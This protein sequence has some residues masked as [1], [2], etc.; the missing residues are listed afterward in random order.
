MTKWDTLEPLTKNIIKTAS[1]AAGVY[2]LAFVAKSIR[3][4]GHALPKF[5]DDIDIE[6][7]LPIMY[8]YTMAHALHRVYVVLKREENYTEEKFKQ[9]K[10]CITKLSEFMTVTLD[11]EDVKK[12]NKMIEK[13]EDLFKN[14]VNTFKDPLTLSIIEQDMELITGAMSAH[15]H[16]LMIDK[17]T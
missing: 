4:S 9:L 7:L 13:I 17:F 1:A 5:D 2:G 12:S 6:V 14:L 3:K 16:N 11:D 15:L 10:T 8:D